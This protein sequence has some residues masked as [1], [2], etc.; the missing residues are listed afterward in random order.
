MYNREFKYKFTVTFKRKFDKFKTDSR[1]VSYI[2]NLVCYDGKYIV[3][4]Y[5][6]CEK[7]TKTF[8]LTSKKLFRKL[9]KDFKHL[10]N[11]EFSNLLHKC[12]NTCYK[13][14]TH[15]INKCPQNII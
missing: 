7:N 12:N 4:V 3:R 2:G 8:N 14:T 1:A 13:Y 15:A 5:K 6:D 11:V 9:E 10:K